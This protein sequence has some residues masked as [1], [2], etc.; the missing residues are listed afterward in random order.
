MKF[1]PPAR[2]LA[3]S[4]AS[5]LLF[6]FTWT[7]LAQPHPGDKLFE[8][9]FTAPDALKPYAPHGKGAAAL[10]PREPDNP[11]LH[12]TATAVPGNTVRRTLP[13]DQIRGLRLNFSTSVKAQDVATPPQRYNG[14][15]FM[16][17]TTSPAGSKWFHPSDLH[18]TFDWKTIRFVADVPP[19]IQSA[20]LILGIEATTGQ[21]WFDDISVTVGVQPQRRRRPDKPAAQ[22]PLDRRTDLPRLR[23][24]MYGPRGRAEDIE[25]LAEWNVN[26]IRWQLHWVERGR[27]D[28]WKDNLEGYDKWLNETLDHLDTMLPLCQKHG[29]KVLIDLHTP[30]GGGIN[31]GPWALFREKKYQDHFIKVWERII[32]RY[33]GNKTVWGYDLANEPIEGFVEPGCLTWRELALKVA[34]RIHL[35]DSEHA[36]IVEPGPGGDWGNLEFFEPLPVPGV[37]YSP[38]MYKPGAFTHQ[39]IHGNPT[40]ITYPGVVQ[41]QK[42]DKQRLRQNLMEIREYQLDYNVPIFM[43]EFSAIRWAPGESARDYLADVIDIF[44]EFGWDWTYH[45][46]REWSG[47]SVE[48]GSDPKDTKPSTTPTS[49]EKLLRS[50]FDKNQRDR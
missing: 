34:Q 25:K 32:E 36:I 49:R 43:G 2:G 19:D 11:A 3:A 20:T 10:E 16:L 48:H 44:E 38:H 12:V 46:F 7:T 24:V 26:L 21:A 27:H 33:K 13:A 31:L 15:K 8:E 5:V 40:G 18:G 35:L 45:A 47:W 1:P 9:S 4:A 37:I 22:G 17:H 42:W 23:G 28:L 41:G 39:G 50:W 29:I 30:P 14:V 6:L